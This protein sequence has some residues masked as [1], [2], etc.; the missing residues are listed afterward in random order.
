MGPSSRISSRRWNHAQ[1]H[2]GIAAE[3][4]ESVIPLDG[5]NGI[6]G[7]WSYAKNWLYPYR[8]VPRKFFHLYLGEVCWRFNNRG[9]DQFPLILALLKHIPFD[10]IRPILVQIR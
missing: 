5:I 2:R 4:Q 9:C 7:F 3:Q 1:A 10:V 8:G 6:E